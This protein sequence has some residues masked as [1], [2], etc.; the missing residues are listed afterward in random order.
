MRV[1]F[2]CI[3]DLDVLSEGY[4]T[5][6]IKITCVFRDWCF[7]FQL[8]DLVRFY[9][10]KR[11]VGSVHGCTLSPDRTYSV[12]TVSDSFYDDVSD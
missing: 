3:G 6:V 2:T 1:P 5:L 8:L 10:L 12:S 7:L 9:S 4:W 11:R